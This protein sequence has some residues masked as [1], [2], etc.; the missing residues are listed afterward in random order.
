MTNDENVDHKRS[1]DGCGKIYIHGQEY[2]V[3]DLQT[4]GGIEGRFNLLMRF[5]DVM[6]EPDVFSMNCT[7]FF[8]FTEHLNIIHIHTCHLKCIIL[9]ERMITLGRG[10]SFSLCIQLSHGS[11]SHYQM[12]QALLISD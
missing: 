1:E 4:R 2:L 11:S 8:I 5:N 7:Y 6:R 9:C 12:T 10:R 3:A